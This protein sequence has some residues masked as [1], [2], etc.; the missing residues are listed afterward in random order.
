MNINSLMFGNNFIWGT[1]TAAYQV[2]GAYNEDGRCESIWDRFSH[3]EGNIYKNHNGDVAC[4]HYHRYKEDVAIMKNLGIKAYRFST[5]WPRIFSDGKSKIN[6][7][8]ID[9][10]NRL[11]DELVGNNIEPFITLYHWDLPQ[12]LEDN[13]GWL[14]RDTGKYYNDYVNVIVDTL[15]DRVKH[16]F[17]FNEIKMFVLIGYGHVSPVDVH[18]PGKNYGLKELNQIR[19]NVLV[20]HGNAVR[21]IKE[22]NPESKVGIAHA[23]E[24]SVPADDFTA[25]KENIERIF[26]ID[27]DPIFA[28]L[29]LGEYPESL[30]KLWGN[31]SP[32][33]LENDMEIISTPVDVI[34][35]NIYSAKLIRLNQE[36]NDFE[37]VEYPSDYP[38]TLMGW[39]INSD[40]L[41]WGVKMVSDIYFSKEIYITENGASFD[42]KPDADNKVHDPDRIKF[43]KAYLS[44]LHKAVSEGVKVRGYFL[45]SLMDNFEWARGYK[46]KFGIVYIDRENGL[47]RIIKDSGYWYK[48]WIAGDSA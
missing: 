27:N 38:R 26:R 35:L 12:V 7:K 14:N 46:Q 8:G 6:Q 43:L 31:N 45:W 15:K 44:K 30:L 29:Y 33:I 37:N 47:K 17:T 1:A 9:F 34:G 42:D 22:L 23:P 32:E 25:Q 21:I 18:A 4:D 19:H 39:P 11:V 40:A 48:A 28:P 2:E 41:F 24:V 36:T 3:I 20:A 13:G 16:W 10:Y 5:A